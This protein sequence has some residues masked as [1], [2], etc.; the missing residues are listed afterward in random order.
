MPAGL[1]VCGA[2]TARSLWCPPNDEVMLD[3]LVE[4]FPNVGV[5]GLGVDIVLFAHGVGNV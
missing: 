1:R 5:G 4:K 2:R 3:Q